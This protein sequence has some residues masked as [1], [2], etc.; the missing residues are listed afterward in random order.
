[1][2]DVIALAVYWVLVSL[3]AAVIFAAAPRRWKT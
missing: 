1:M 3:I 2:D